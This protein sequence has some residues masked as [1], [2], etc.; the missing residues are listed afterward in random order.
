MDAWTIL[1]VDARS[2]INMMPLLWEPLAL[3]ILHTSTLQT[4]HTELGFEAC[5]SHCEQ[6]AISFAFQTLF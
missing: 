6:T 5:F 2:M 3:T 1:L 4:I